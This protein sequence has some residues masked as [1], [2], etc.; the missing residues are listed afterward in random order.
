MK[1]RKKNALPLLDLESSSS[2]SEYETE[3]EDEDGSSFPS[4]SRSESSEWETDEDGAEGEQPEGPAIEQ[5]DTAG[6]LSP[7][8]AELE[9]GASAVSDHGAAGL[10]AVDPVRQPAPQPDPMTISAVQY[11]LGR[12]SR[13][14]GG[15]VRHAVAGVH[16]S[17]Q[18]PDGTAPVEGECSGREEQEQEC[19]ELASE[20]ESDDEDEG[21]RRAVAPGFNPFSLLTS[22][23]EDDTDAQDG[24]EWDDEEVEP[25]VD[26][27]ERQVLEDED[28]EGDEQ[29]DWDSE[30]S[31]DGYLE[32]EA[33]GAGPDAAAGVVEARGGREEAIRAAAGAGETAAGASAVEAGPLAAASRPTAGRGGDG[34]AAASPPGAAFIGPSAGAVPATGAG[35]VELCASELE[36]RCACEPQASSGDRGAAAAAGG[37]EGAGASAAA[38]P[39][40]GT[41][42]L[43]RAAGDPL[44][45]QLPAGD[46]VRM[47]PAAE[48]GAG[49]QEQ[50]AAAAPQDGVCESNGDAAECWV[51]YGSGRPVGCGLGGEAAGACGAHADGTAA[52]GLAD[53]GEALVAPCRVCAGGVRYIHRRCFVQW[54]E[55]SWAVTCPN[56]RT[57]YD[58]SVLE[59]FTDS[60]S[61]RA[62]WAAACL[63]S[64][65]PRR[66]FPYNSMAHFCVGGT[67][68]VAMSVGGLTAVQLL[69][70]VKAMT[71]EWR[72]AGADGGLGLVRAD[73]SR[74]VLPS[75]E[76][77][78]LVLELGGGEE[79]EW[80]LYDGGMAGAQERH[81]DQ[82]EDDEMWDPV[83]PVWGHGGGPVGAYAGGDVAADAGDYRHRPRSPPPGAARPHA[84]AIAHDGGGSST[85]AGRSRDHLRGAHA[86]P[87]GA[88]YAADMSPGG[89]GGGAGEADNPLYRDTL[90]R[91]A[92][93]MHRLRTRHLHQ[94]QNM[95][96]NLEAAAALQQRRQ[97]EQQ[98][99]QPTAQPAGGAGGLFADLRVP[100]LS[101]LQPGE[102]AVSALAAGWQRGDMHAMPMPVP[103]RVDGEFE[104]TAAERAAQRAEQRRRREEAMRQQRVL[105]QRHVAQQT[106]QYGASGAQRFAGGSRRRQ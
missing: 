80:G 37:V 81:R 56:C 93:I 57:L 89:G 24:G 67:V 86:P 19:E 69:R 5:A 105:T 25:G 60:G 48:L 100:W 66:P 12:I 50:V 63:P 106:R 30:D 28:D 77:T 8:D 4:G 83:P 2:G 53:A 16:D 98:G 94:L 6:Q 91:A 96:G 92:E 39:V 75:F 95:D 3:G 49:A 35:G 21:E 1:L 34:V 52:G 32:V 76:V 54:L 85:S 58:R 40:D 74:L 79:A 87:R 103:V 65:D 43:T 64:H 82:E 71:D 59:A 31:G 23:D 29:R 9:R 62:L 38:G 33:A 104:R 61:L 70:R 27:E 84:D 7:G 44:A 15:A 73:G 72:L 41:A 10:S 90:A 97:Q 14:R 78:G 36:R 45:A 18:D 13:P 20:G 101:M 26:A 17:V 88:P 68:E 102:A 22:S 42:A 11:Q 46:H 55:S 47:R 99:S 51:C